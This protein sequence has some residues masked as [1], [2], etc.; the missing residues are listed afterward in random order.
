MKKVLLLLSSVLACV[1]AVLGASFYTARPVNAADE[2]DT[3]KY[4]LTY[5]YIA[6]PCSIEEAI[7]TTPSYRGTK[8][9]EGGIYECGEEVTIDF[10]PPTYYVRDENNVFSEYRFVRFVYQLHEDGEIFSVYPGD[11]ISFTAEDVQD[12]LAYDDGTK[13]FTLQSVYSQRVLGKVHKVTFLSTPKFETLY[14][15]DGQ[16]LNYIE[17]TMEG[18]NFDGWYT[19]EAFTSKFDFENY[20]VN[21][22]LKLYPKFTKQAEK[23]KTE[24]ET[25]VDGLF[26]AA[27]VKG[28]EFSVQVLILVGLVVLI[29]S[30]FK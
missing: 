26:N 23:E 21:N 12:L 1:F 5:Q 30:I 19:D 15:E 28:L 16:K 18:Y 9:C 17:Q 29:I 25:Q 2:T 10:T 4:E 14:V 3:V 6:T 7:K 13:L 20:T 27:G 24:I 8:F 22:D 11:K